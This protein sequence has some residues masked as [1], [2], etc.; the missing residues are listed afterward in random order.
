MVWKLGAAEV[1]MLWARWAALV[2]G[3]ERDTEPHEIQ[4]GGG[5]CNGGWTSCFTAP[6][7]GGFRVVLLGRWVFWC[8]VDLRMARFTFLGFFSFFFPFLI[9]RKS[10]YF[11]YHL[12]NLI[13]SPKITT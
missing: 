3:K 6:V 1:N 8:W 9:S 11:S 2:G 4:S 7:F 5:W 13:S 10:E 12:F